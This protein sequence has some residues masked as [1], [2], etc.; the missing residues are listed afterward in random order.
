[1]LAGGMVC[2]KAVCLVEKKAD[3]MVIELAARWAGMWVGWW[4]TTL[5]VVM[6][7]LTVQNEAEMTEYE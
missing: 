2:S 5:A 4:G 3:M 6:V 7:E 1:M